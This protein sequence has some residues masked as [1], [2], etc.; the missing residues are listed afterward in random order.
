MLIQ[1][2]RKVHAMGGAAKTVTCRGQAKLACVSHNVNSV[3]QVAE[4]VSWVQVEAGFFG[5]GGHEFYLAKL[6]LGHLGASSKPVGT[7]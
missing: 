5:A 2:G 4:V 7:G 3:A 6:T 1:I